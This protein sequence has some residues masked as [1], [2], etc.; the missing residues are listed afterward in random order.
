MSSAIRFSEPDG[1]DKFIAVIIA[2]RYLSFSQNG[3]LDA[4]VSQNT[5]LLNNPD[6]TKDDKLVRQGHQ[7]ELTEGESQKKF[8]VILGDVISRDPA[9]VGRSTVVL[10]ATSDKWPGKNLVVKIS[11]PGHG[12]VPEDE[13]LKK[14]ISEAERTDGKWAINHLPRVYFSKDVVFSDDST[15]MSVAGLFKNAKFSGGGYVYEQRAL[16]IIIQEELYPL[17]SLT[18]VR[19]VSQVFVDI[20]CSMYLFRLLLV[21]THPT[22]VHRWL[23]DHP[24]ILHRDLSLNNIMW[25]LIEQMDANKKSEQKVYGVLTD[26]DLSSWTEDLKNGYKNTSLQRTGTPPYMALELLDETSSVHL[27][28]HDVESLFYVMLLTCG[29]HVFGPEKAEGKEEGTRRMIRRGGVLPYQ[30]WFGQ[31]DHETLGDKKTVFFTKM[32]SIDLSPH[33][34]DFQPWLEDLQLR[35]SEGFSAKSAS[36]VKQKKRQRLGTSSAEVD[37]FD[38][39][40]LG[41]HIQYSSFIEPVR[42][43]TGELKKL[44][45]RYDP[46]Q[47]PLPAS[48]DVTEVNS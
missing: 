31:P 9:A 35:F 41:G 46:S 19:D 5:E 17:K 42:H 11:W 7:L 6:I 45:I 3:I 34:E 38:D 23:H 28:R 24:G 1:L 8:K 16:R 29:R 33:F 44:A 26:Y 48:A 18:N 22:L 30:K 12:R 47:I 32:Q 40:T 21:F 4:L 27:Y 2:F 43:L 36:L 15:F 37:Q 13:F 10:K 20:A 39:E 14:A 25:R